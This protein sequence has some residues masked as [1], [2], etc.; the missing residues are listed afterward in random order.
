[1]ET[2]ADTHNSL[3]RRLILQRKIKFPKEDT[4]N[5]KTQLNLNIVSAKPKLDF[6]CNL[7]MLPKMYGV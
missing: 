4:K 1:M 6:I 3:R 5:T 7:I 2:I